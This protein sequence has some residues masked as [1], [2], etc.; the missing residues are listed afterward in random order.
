MTRCEGQKNIIIVKAMEMQ[1]EI[2]EMEMI[3]MKVEVIGNF[4][5]ECC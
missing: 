1:M 2:M 4:R 3:S 5:D